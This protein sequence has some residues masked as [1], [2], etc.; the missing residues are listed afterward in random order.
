MTNYGIP[1]LFILF[2]IIIIP[3]AALLYSLVELARD[4]SQN[5]TTKAIWVLVI[6]AVPI[7]GPVVYLIIGKNKGSG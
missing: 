6:L 3:L 4:S 5:G 2:V 1:E 7:I